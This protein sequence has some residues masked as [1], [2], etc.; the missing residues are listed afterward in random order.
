MSLASVKYTE[1]FE[2][3]SMKG[4]RFYAI[5]RVAYVWSEL[6]STHYRNVDKTFVDRRMEDVLT[7]IMDR[8]NAPHVIE[9]HLIRL[10]KWLHE[11]TLHDAPT[12]V[13]EMIDAVT[14]KEF[15][16]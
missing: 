6:C 2:R 13:R 11:N 8:R 3:G 12:W 14:I 4:W 16:K 1:S 10:R 9:D 5:H 7:V 15:L